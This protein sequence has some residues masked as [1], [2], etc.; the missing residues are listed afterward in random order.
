MKYYVY[1]LKR[2]NGKP[3][4]VGKGTRSRIS[5][6]VWAA[7]NGRIGHLYNV[8]RK[9]V[10]SGQNVIQHKVQDGMT[11]DE[12]VFLE[13]RLIAEIGRKKD[14]GPLVN[15]TDGGDGAPGYRHD[16]VAKMKMS[17]ARDRYVC[18]EETR[19][20]MGAAHAGKRH[21]EEAKQKLRAIKGDRHWN[22]GKTISVEH[23]KKLHAANCR[24]VSVNGVR[25]ESVSAAAMAFGVSVA[26]AGYRARSGKNRGNKYGEW[27]YV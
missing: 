10:A 14:G 24:A 15:I 6:H 17:E 23:A 22:F 13:R 18:S 11:N 4:Y 5:F 25:Y 27:K 26:T 7:K 9:I 3:F 20:K 16:L 2:P 8:I 21:T 1:M 12:A 19:K